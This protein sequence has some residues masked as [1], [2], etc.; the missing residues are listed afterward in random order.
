M[1]MTAVAMTVAIG[2]AG[3]AVDGGLLY[4]HHHRL[5]AA[6]DAAALAAVRWLPGAPAVAE[7]EAT[8]I[9]RA[10]SRLATQVDMRWPYQNDR[11]RVEV[12]VE[13]S[14]PVYFMRV[15]GFGDVGARGRAVARLSAPQAFN[16]ALFSGSESEEL[17]ISGSDLLIDGHAHTNSSAR[18][19]GSN[20]VTTG[21]FE[22]TGTLQ[23]T[24]QGNT[25]NPAVSNAS[26]VPMPAFDA[27]ALR[28][29][30]EAN[31]TVYSTSQHFPSHQA[32]NGVL[33]VQ[34]DVHLSGTV[35]GVGA[36]VATGDITISGHLQYQNQ[37][38][39]LALIAGGDVDISGSNLDISGIIYAP[40]GQITVSGSNNTFNGA[41]VANELKLSGSNITINYDP[42]ATIGLPYQRARLS[43]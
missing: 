20:N 37:G 39:A 43:E 40:N 10:N 33:F 17:R 4:V 19:S 16:Y 28:A 18:V 29:M 38:S 35:E 31:G 14:F 32:V 2:L 23:F 9:A 41:L 22:A 5:Q 27:D 34:G 6:A 24:G 30:A 8:E 12:V 21:R 13:D 11:S 36:I 3:L 1:V 26:H 25:A 7:A 15:L 42:N